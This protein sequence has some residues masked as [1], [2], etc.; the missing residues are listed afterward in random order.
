MTAVTRFA[1]SPTG[2]LHI[3]GARTALFNWLFARR[4]GGRFLL[5]I[6]DTDRRRSTEEAVAAILD[7]LAWLGLDPDEP[8]S[9]QFERRARHAEVANAMLEA[10]SAY[11]CYAGPK[12]LEAMRTAAT[13][14]GERF[15]YDGLWRDRADEAF[16]NQRAMRPRWETYQIAETACNPELIGRPIT[17]VAAERGVRPLDVLLDAAVDD[18]LTTRISCIIANDDPDGVAMLLRQDGCTLGLSD[19]GAHVG[20]LCDAPQATDFLGHWVRDRQ[21]MP[22]EKAVRKLST[23][24]A[25]MFNLKD[26]G[27]LRPGAYADV[28]VSTLT[29]WPLD[30]CA[31]FETF[32]P[33]PSG[34]PP[35]PRWASPMCW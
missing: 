26:R 13:S 28:V 31:G 11:R 18:N 9:Y 35:T 25:D 3:G 34:S 33:T 1:P 23:V 4:Y 20:Q 10:G 17:D 15:R 32:P 12:E 27:R 29:P 8:P 2:L 14:R 7:G 19:A 22:L 16:K 24:Q 21:L 5:R 30:R 6:E